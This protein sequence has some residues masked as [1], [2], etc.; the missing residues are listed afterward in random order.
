MTFT[1]WLLAAAITLTA[2]DSRGSEAAPTAE[3]AVAGYVCT[4]EYQ[5]W[6]TGDICFGP[7]SYD[8]R[9]K[10][11]AVMVE[12][13]MSY[14]IKAAAFWWDS[15][16]HTSDWLYHDTIIGPGGNVQ[17]Q[18]SWNGGNYTVYV[19]CISGSPRIHNSNGQGYC[20]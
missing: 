6:I 17:W 5:P 19:W 8:W 4:H 7:N 15:V 20:L 11:G 12:N 14:N 18:E 16:A 2:I 1:G 3:D 13:G 9:G 10:F